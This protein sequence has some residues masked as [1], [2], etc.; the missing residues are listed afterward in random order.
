MRDIEGTGPDDEPAGT[1][2]VCVRTG[3]SLPSIAS[4][5]SAACYSNSMP[6]RSV[7]ALGY[8]KS[9]LSSVSTRIS[10]TARLRNQFLLEGITYQGAKSVLHFRSMSLYAAM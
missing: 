2:T 1:A 7:A 8:F 10:A 9:I 3:S 4:D 6:S 5:S